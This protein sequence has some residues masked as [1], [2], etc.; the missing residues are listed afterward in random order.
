MYTLTNTS[1]FET[2]N[3]MNSRFNISSLTPFVSKKLYDIVYSN[4][5]NNC[6]S[7]SKEK[8]VLYTY[9]EDLEPSL[10]KTQ[11]KICNNFDKN[12]FDKKFSRLSI[13]YK[14]KRD[15]IF[16][17]D[18]RII[19]MNPSTNSIFLGSNGLNLSTKSINQNSFK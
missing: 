2:P 3:N 17:K 15:E 6:N 1:H 9:K 13:T 12:K 14:L 8:L 16:K 7:F 5:N 4:E 18:L 11:L 10:T 19:N